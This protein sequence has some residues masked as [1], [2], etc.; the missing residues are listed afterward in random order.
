[1]SVNDK[2]LKLSTAARSQATTLEVLSAELHR[3]A[4]AIARAQAIVA[5]LTAETS[6]GVEG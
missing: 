5:A 1:M 3:I 4:Q 6:S 2:Y